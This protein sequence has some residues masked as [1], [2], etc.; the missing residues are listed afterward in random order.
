MEEKE[1]LRLKIKNEQIV[2]HDLLNKNLKK[3]IVR[4]RIAEVLY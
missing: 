2:M 1:N 4:H 3:P